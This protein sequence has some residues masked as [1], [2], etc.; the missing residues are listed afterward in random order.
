MDDVVIS[1]EDADARLA[2]LANGVS[3]LL[4]LRNHVD[5]GV[6]WRYDEIFNLIEEITSGYYY[7]FR[8]N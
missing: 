7:F 2:P 6:S 8:L 1:M 4:S 5:F 3:A